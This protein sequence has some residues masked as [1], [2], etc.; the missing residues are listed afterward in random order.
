MKDV[1]DCR[2]IYCF[3]SGP[4][5]WATLLSAGFA[6][7]FL[8]LYFCSSIY[9]DSGGWPY[10]A[11]CFSRVLPRLVDQKNK[12]EPMDA[13]STPFSGASSVFRAALS[14]SSS[15]CPPRECR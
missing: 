9:A 6:P 11:S 8:L 12:P 7:L 5:L 3:Y 10:E 13:A 1:C 4:L 15:P 14:L 2:K